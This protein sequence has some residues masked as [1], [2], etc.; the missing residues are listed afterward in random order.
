[1]INATTNVAPIANFER[2]LFIDSFSALLAFKQIGELRKEI[3][4]IMRAGGRFRMLLYAED[5]HFLVAHPF[6]RVVIQIDVTHFNIFR[7]RLGID[8]ETVI[9]RGDRDFAAF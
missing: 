5:G 1:M 4:R 9:L 8:R 2:F 6:D 3:G 7:Q